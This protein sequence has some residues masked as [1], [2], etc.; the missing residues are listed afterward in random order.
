MPKLSIAPLNPAKRL[1]PGDSGQFSYPAVPAACIDPHEQT[2]FGRRAGELQPI[3]EVPRTD[4]Q[5]WGGQ[6]AAAARALLEP[7]VTPANEQ[8]IRT[9]HPSLGP[10]EG[11]CVVRE[12]S[13]KSI[14]LVA[15]D[16][17]VIPTTHA[18]GREIHVFP[19]GILEQ[20]ALSPLIPLQWDPINVVL[21][22]RRFLS[23]NDLHML[24]VM[25]PSAVGARVFIGGFIVILFRSQADIKKS[26]TRDG[27]ASEF[28][29]LRLLYDVIEDWASREEVC[30]ASAIASTPNSLDTHASLGLK[31]RFANGQEAITVPTHAFVKLGHLNSRPLLR[32]AD[33]Y[34][35]AKLALSRLAPLKRRSSEP[36]IGTLRYEEAGNSPLGKSVYLAGESKKIGVITSTYDP[37]SSDL[38]RFPSGFLH[39]LSL[40]TAEEGGSL[41]TIISP[42]GTPRVNGWGDYQRVLDGDPLFVL[43]FN[44]ATGTQV[45][46]TGWGI[47]PNARKAIAEG[48][49]YIWDKQLCS[50]NISLLWRTE[51]VGDHLQGFSSSALCLGSPSD[52][53]CEAVCFQNFEFNLSSRDLLAVDYRGASPRRHPLPVIKGGFILPAEVREAEILCEDKEV[54]A[55]PG[56]FPGQERVSTELRRSFFSHR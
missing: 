23:R 8:L 35:R 45:R 17:F 49:E 9:H 47:L 40:V 10:I 48:T 56:T 36:D 53:T 50:Q 2:L 1:Y 27:L 21:N 26:W 52:K 20:M 14:W 42:D 12:S 25:F 13:E 24:R 4:S 18:A 46:R 34:A 19:N 39:D 37:V 7:E 22:P 29:T 44:L 54:S 6:I 15:P 16:T 11:V 41:P 31:V 55:A 3:D 51:M 32:M 30:G 38:M 5:E 33:W 43:A 28:G